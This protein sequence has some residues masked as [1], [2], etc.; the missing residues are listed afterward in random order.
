ML[1]GLAHVCL[2]R[3]F[4]WLFFGCAK[5]GST[6]NQYIKFTRFTGFNKLFKCWDELFT[7]NMGAVYLFLIPRSLPVLSHKS[8]ALRGKSN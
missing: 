7:G 3:S 6:F 4:S 1:N 5:L 2:S 8:E